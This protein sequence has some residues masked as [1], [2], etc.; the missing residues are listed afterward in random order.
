MKKY[1]V[2]WKGR[3]SGIFESWPQAE[4]QVKGYPN[5]QYKAFTSLTEAQQALQGRYQDYAASPTSPKPQ[6]RLAVPPPR[7][8]SLCVDAACSGNPGLLEYRCVELRADGEAWDCAARGAI[9]GREVFRRGPFAQGTNNIG[10]FLAIVEALMYCQKSGCDWPIYSDSV[11][12]L[13]W[14]RAKKARTNLKPTEANAPLFAR[15]AQAEA[16]LRQHTYPNPVLKWQ[17]EHWGEN[18]ADFGRK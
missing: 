18:P 4:A 13:A 2:V 16:W 6:R 5:A 7:L 14:V 10:E 3:Q 9:L 12:A 15:V 8:P 1:Y 17:T 11:N